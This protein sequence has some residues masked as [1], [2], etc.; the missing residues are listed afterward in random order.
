[1]QALLNDV[2]ATM[3]IYDAPDGQVYGLLAEFKH[4]GALLDA[5]KKTREAGY[6]RFDTYSPF[7]VH[8][9][10]AAMG[11]GNSKI[12]FFAIAGGIAGLSLA[13][14]M[15]WWTGLV[16]YPM[17]IS[18]KPLFAFESATP[19]NFELTILL[20]ALT[21]VLGMLVLNGLPRPWNPLF[22]SKNFRRATDDGFFLQIA[23][24]D[25]RFDLEATRSFLTEAGAVH[26]ELLSEPEADAAESAPAA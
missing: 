12:G 20:T 1:M 18:G 21:A 8:G 13:I 22:Y 3:S 15:Q 2:K 19:V 9:M 25:P 14:W 5:A 17:N 6:K 26:V 10:D 7:P 4:P 11:L 23:A 24:N 16:D